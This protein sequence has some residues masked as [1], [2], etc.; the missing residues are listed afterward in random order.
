M[1]CQFLI[2]SKVTQ[3]YIYTYIYIFSFSHTILDQVPLQVTRYSSLCNTQHDVIVYPLQRQYFASINHKVSVHPTP[4]PSPLATTSL[5][6]HEFLQCG[7]VHLCRILDSRYKWY[8]MVFVFLLLTY[9]TYMRVSSFIY[10][11]ANGI[12]FFFLWLSIP[13][14]IYTTSS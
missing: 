11:A 9:F 14:C 3:S 1:F 4:F 8:Y 12:I 13:L 5:Q 6:V 7:K 10:V 2:Y